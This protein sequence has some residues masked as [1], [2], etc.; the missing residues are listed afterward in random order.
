MQ[1]TTISKE[2]QFVLLDL[3]KPW[4]MAEAVGFKSTSPTY[5]KDLTQLTLLAAK[6]LTEPTTGV[7][8]GPKVGY[9]ALDYKH[10]ATGVVLSLD[11]NLYA[12][13]PLNLPTFLSDWG[14]EHIKNNYGVVKL[15][16]PYNPKEEL[17]AEKKK[18]LAEVYDYAQY[19]KVDLV[20]ELK[21]FLLE[22]VKPSQ[23]QDVFLSTQLESVRELQN[24]VDLFILDF[25]FTPLGCATLTA[26][27]DVPWLVNDPG[28]DY[29]K[30]KENL[31]TALDGGASGMQIGL[32]LYNQAPKGGALT[33]EFLSL[34]E[35]FL[36][37]EARDRVLELARIVKEASVVSL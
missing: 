6:Y 34:W 16:L 2:D 19:E 25:P 9:S 4:Q 27:L 7:V 11:N 35:Q 18:L 10:P 37:T 26:E 3:D 8:L 28:G 1:L 30:V 21:V 13:D 33:A 36:K 29:L 5:E 14:V 23:K 12:H 24:M 17:A 20:V 32:S 15:T 31:R 22:K